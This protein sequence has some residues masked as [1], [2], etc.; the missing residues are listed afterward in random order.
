MNPGIAILS[1][2][3]GKLGANYLSGEGIFD[4]ITGLIFL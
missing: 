3:L 1:M 4:I 2:N